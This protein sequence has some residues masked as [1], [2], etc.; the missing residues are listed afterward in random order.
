[1][2]C[3]STAWRRS[4]FAVLLAA[5]VGAPSSVASAAERVALVMGN[6]TYEVAA[7]SN[8]AND[9]SEVSAALERLGFD[10]T[11]LLDATRAAMNEALFAFAEESEDG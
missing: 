11:L 1:M 10:V 8:P 6:S 7:L 2:R 5:G 9:A 3:D 4:L